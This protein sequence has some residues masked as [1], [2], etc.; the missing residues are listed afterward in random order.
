M[1]P[2]KYNLRQAWSALREARKGNGISQAIFRKWAD[3]NAFPH[4]NEPECQE[5]AT[6]EQF[7]RKHI[8]IWYSE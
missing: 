7:T 3:V 5:I 6:Y 1:K 4:D 2:E 8:Q